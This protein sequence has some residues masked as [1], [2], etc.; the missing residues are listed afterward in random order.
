MLRTLIGTGATKGRK[1]SEHVN[2]VRHL[3]ET[4]RSISNSWKRQF[5]EKEAYLASEVLIYDA[6]GQELSPLDNVA[7]DEESADQCLIEKQERDRI[8]RFFKDDSDAAFVLGGLFEG[9][10]RNEIIRQ[11]CLTESQYQSAIRRIRAKLSGGRKDPDGP[12]EGG[13]WK[14]RKITMSS[15]KM[16]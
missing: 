1:W 15:W 12:N 8:I 10:K 9:M 4:V 11:G 3:A 7:S 14:V 2:F 16:S 6:E 13:T 5:K